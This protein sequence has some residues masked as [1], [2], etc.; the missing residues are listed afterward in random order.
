MQVPVF[1]DV[2][3]R[4]PWWRLDK[5]DMLLRDAIQVKLNQ[6]ELDTLVDGAGRTADAKAQQLQSRYD[7][8]QVNVTLGRNGAIARNYSEAIYT[9]G[10]E[11]GSIQVVDTVGAGDA[12]TSVALLG[13]M[14]GWPL[15]RTMDRAQQFASAIVSVRGAVIGEQESYHPFIQRWELPQK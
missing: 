14:L 4:P 8:E 3:M 1:L 6:D 15:Q 11:A 5:V 9:P 12:F 7:I 10:P 2:N 13:F